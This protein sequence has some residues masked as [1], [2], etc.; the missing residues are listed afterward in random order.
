MD[1]VDSSW[2]LKLSS[3]CAAC[4]ITAS[5]SLEVNMMLCDASHQLQA[6]SGLRCDGALPR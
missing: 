1:E 2:V 5:K 6:C 3:Q 4:C